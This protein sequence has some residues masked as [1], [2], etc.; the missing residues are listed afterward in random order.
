MGLLNSRQSNDFLPYNNLKTTFGLVS[1]Y[2]ESTE[3]AR[4]IFF[5]KRETA[6]SFFFPILLPVQ[7]LDMTFLYL[8]PSCIKYNLNF[9]NFPS[10]ENTEGKVL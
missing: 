7:C 9:Q 8:P 10:F 5:S 2:T 3:T 6:L 4:A 1:L